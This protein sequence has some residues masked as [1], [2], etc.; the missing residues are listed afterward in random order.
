M[1]DGYGEDVQI[2]CDR[3]G[4]WLDDA[5]DYLAHVA[6]AHMAPWRKLA[7]GEVWVLRDGS[8]HLTHAMGW[9]S[10]QLVE[11]QVGEYSPVDARYFEGYAEAIAAGERRRARS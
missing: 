10:E 11:V 4:A 9:V 1:K 6:S 3:C 2:S 8:W 5:A 7:N